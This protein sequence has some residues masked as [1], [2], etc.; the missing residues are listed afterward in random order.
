MTN[1]N[2]TTPPW[3]VNASGMPVG[4]DG[5]LLVGCHI[6]VNAAG[7]A[8]QFT[9]PNITEVLSTTTGTTLPTPTFSFPTFSYKDQDW[10]ISVTSLPANANGGGTWSTPG[11]KK[12]TGSQNGDYTAQAGTGTDEDEADE[13]ASRAKA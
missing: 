7:T 9:K 4:S 1:P 11:G 3:T 8:Y 10:T 12:R 5:L 13:A 2:T 6:T